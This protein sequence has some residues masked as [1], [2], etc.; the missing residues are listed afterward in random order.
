M[1]HFEREARLMLFLG[2]LPAVGV[3]IAV[4]APRIFRLL[5]W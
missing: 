5:G 3:F 1:N 4:V 2:L